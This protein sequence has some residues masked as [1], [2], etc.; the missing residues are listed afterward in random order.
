LRKD[1]YNVQES[2]A[3]H[4]LHEVFDLLDSLRVRLRQ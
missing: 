1:V 4:S 2:E 3:Y